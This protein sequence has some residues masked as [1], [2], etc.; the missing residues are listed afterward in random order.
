MFRPCSD[1]A[2]R[3]TTRL[4]NFEQSSGLTPCYVWLMLRRHS[5]WS[6]TVGPPPSRQT[7]DVQRLLDSADLTHGVGQFEANETVFSRCDPANN[8]MFMEVGIVRVKAVVMRLIL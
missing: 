8:L 1:T 6:V 5:T 3:E 2:Q 7:F 4:Y